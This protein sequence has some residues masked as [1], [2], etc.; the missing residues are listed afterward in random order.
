[1][2]LLEKDNGYVKAGSLQ[3][4]QRYYYKFFNIKKY[5]N[6]SNIEEI[7]QNYMEG[8]L[9]TS[10]YYFDKCE[11]WN[12]C[13]KYLHGPTIKELVSYFDICFDKLCL[14]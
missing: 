5:Q 3:W 11:S 10:K 14:L 8:L 6:N 2:P 4:R 9:W 12:W 13:Y 7:C 1:M